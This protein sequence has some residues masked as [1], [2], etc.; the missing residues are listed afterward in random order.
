[1]LLMAKGINIYNKL[2]SEINTIDL[3]RFKRKPKT[4][5]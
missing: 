2:G 1:M 4:F 5:Y 3:K